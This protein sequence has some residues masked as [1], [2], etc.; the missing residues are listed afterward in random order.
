MH[1]HCYSPDSCLV[2]APYLFLVPVICIPYIFCFLGVVKQTLCFTFLCELSKSSLNFKSQN[3]FFKE[4]SLLSE[5]TQMYLRSSHDKKLFEFTKCYNDNVLICNNKLL[6]HKFFP[7]Q[8]LKTHKNN[9]CY[10]I[11]A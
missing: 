6:F 5:M 7:Q 10:C 8:H 4:G 11:I 2:V 1:C 3:I 9:I